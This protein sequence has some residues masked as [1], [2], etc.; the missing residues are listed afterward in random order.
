[1][2]PEDIKA[3][4]RREG[5]TSAQIAREL[6]VSKTCVTLV[7][8]GRTKSVRVARRICELSGLDPEIA[9]PG[10]YPEFRLYPIKRRT[11]ASEAA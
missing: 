5:A 11:R 6:N 7:I 2:H 9:W 8:Q 3:S 10:R 4:I 1:M